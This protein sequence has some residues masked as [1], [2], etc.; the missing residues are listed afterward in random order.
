MKPFKSGCQGF[1][2]LYFLILIIGNDLL[3]SYSNF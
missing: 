3:D 2:V 1:L